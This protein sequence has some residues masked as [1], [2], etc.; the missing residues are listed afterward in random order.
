MG[1]TLPFEEYWITKEESI[2]RFSPEVFD[3]ELKWHIDLEDRIIESISENDWKF[4]F[5]DQLPVEM[6]GV[7]NIKKGQWHRL[8]KGT[9]D[10]EVKI[11][12]I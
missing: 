12:R 9:T 2:R 11:R 8:I 5:D 7:I 6:K 3:E 10:L 1:D 4:Q